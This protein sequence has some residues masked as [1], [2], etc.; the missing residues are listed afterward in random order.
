MPRV[1]CSGDL[2]EVRKADR[3]AGDHSTETLSVGRIR[4]LMWGELVE[5]IEISHFQVVPL[6]CN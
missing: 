1:I 2:E 4:Q 5:Y 3:D 6:A